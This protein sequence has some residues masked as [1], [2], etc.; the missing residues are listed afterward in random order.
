MRGI[1]I[2]RLPG[3]IHIISYIHP[4]Q[5]PIKFV[6]IATGS[7]KFGYWKWNRSV[8]NRFF[9]YPSE[10]TLPNVLTDYRDRSS[11]NGTIVSVGSRSI[12][13]IAQ[14]ED[15]VSGRKVKE[16]PGRLSS[17]WTYIKPIAVHDKGKGL[18]LTP[19]WRKRLQRGS[20]GSGFSP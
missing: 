9:F 6:N 4:S 13:R 3:Y 19:E 20:G 16:E 8:A 2:L 1:P 10:N 15:L 5:Y 17:V 14:S 12:A 18:R 7:Q 11:R